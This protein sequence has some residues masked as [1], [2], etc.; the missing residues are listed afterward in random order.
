MFVV[1]AV[2]TAVFANVFLVV[3]RSSFG[4]LLAALRDSPT[5]S[6]MMGMDIVG[7]K[8]KIFGLSALMAGPAGALLGAFQVRVGSL[9]F[10]YFR[11]LTLLL[12]ATIFGIT[13]VSGALLGALFFVVLPEVLRHAAAAAGAAGSPARRPCSR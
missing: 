6:Q 9:D 11:S 8:L 3:R 12:V 4:R 2:A 10:L 13:S 7:T 1:L 5:A